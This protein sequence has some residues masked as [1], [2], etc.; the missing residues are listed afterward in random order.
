MQRDFEL[1]LSFTVV[2]FLA[3]VYVVYDSLAKPSG[4]HPFGH[5]LGILGAGM[6]V[7][8]EVLYS[9][10]KRWHIFRFGQVRHWL[11][12]HIFTG[13]V[14][15]TLVLMHTG[16]AFRGLAGLAMLL[17]VL[18]VVSGFLGR[19]IYTAVP[20]SLAGIEVDRRT[21]EAQARRQQEE[22]LAWTANKSQRLRALIERETAVD[23]GAEPLPVWAVLARRWQDWRAKR[24]LQ[25]AMRQLNR[26]ERARLAEVERLLRQ[27]QRL[28]RQIR[29]LQ[30]ARRLLG[31]WHSFHIPLGLTLFTA[32]IIHIVAALYYKGL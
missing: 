27:Q 23:A 16:L 20:R 13:I 2:L 6:M 25:A 4:G 30:T 5:T 15:P 9:A 24:R 32:V 19:Y 29:S 21:L 11:S 17:T 31:L 3:A 1:K 12:F 10:R 22:L 18:V 26:E 8:T 28:V 14:G 7:M